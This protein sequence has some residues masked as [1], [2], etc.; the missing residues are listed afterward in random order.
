MKSPLCECEAGCL[1]HKEHGPGPALL[2]VTRGGKKVKVCT[3][4]NAPAEETRVLEEADHEEC[5]EFDPLGY[6]TAM[7]GT[8]TREEM[9]SELADSLL[10][11]AKYKTEELG[12]QAIIDLQNLGGT[13]ESLEQATLGWNSLPGPQREFTLQLHHPLFP[14]RYE[15]TP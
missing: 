14:K 9:I 8:L 5:K 1:V 2:E 10:R 4:C 15:E 6:R 7:G 12:V 3:R 13:E 11:F